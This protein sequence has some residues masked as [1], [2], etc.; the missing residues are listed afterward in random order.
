MATEHA[1]TRLKI[2]GF[3]SIRE[4]NLELSNLN[5][6]IG[7]NGS[8]KSNL[9]A[10]FEM[11]RWMVNE[12]LGSWVGL[13]DGADRVL[14]FGAKQT[15]ELSSR[16]EFGDNAY[17]F[18]LR[19]TDSDSLAFMDERLIYA[20]NDSRGFALGS[21]H[22]ETLLK[23]QLR[24]DGGYLRRADYI[25]ASIKSWRVYHFHDTSRSAPVMQTRDLHDCEFLRA[26][27]D[28]LAAY[29]FMLREDQPTVY[30]QI[31]KTVRLAIPFFADFHLRPTKNRHGEDK[32]RLMWQHKRSDRPFLANQLSDGSLR[33]ICLVTALLQ[34]DPPTTI[35][36]DEPEIGLHPH[37]ITLLGALLRSASARMQVIVA[38]QSV[39]LVDEFSIDDLIVVE[40]VD[41][42]SRFERRENAELEGWL[43]DY[44]VGELW[45]S[46]LLGGRLPA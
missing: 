12:R 37:A 34:P 9:V 10:Y 13:R 22:K 24:T 19:H 16:V 3:M 42:V 18:R 17:A 21:G 26:D 1:I 35:I 28:N 32:I 36:I 27:A 33:F 7:P 20:P 6:M 11:L 46:N 38:T 8:G 23:T 44:S 40:Q 30:S 5:V 45:E 31:C 15:Q 41:G 25:D 4:M 29:L 14:C 2:K 43:A 39:R